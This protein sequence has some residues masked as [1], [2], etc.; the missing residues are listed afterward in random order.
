MAVTQ[1]TDARSHRMPAEER[2]QEVIAA[3]I[4]EFARRG[5][6]GTTAEDIARRAGITQPYV[7][8]LFGTKK[9]LF[10]I[11]VGR[12]FDRIQGLFEAALAGLGEDADADARLQAMG[13]SYGELLADRSMLL[14]QMQAYAAGDDPEVRALVQKRFGDL[15]EWIGQVSGAQPIEVQAFFA[16]G[17]LLNVGASIGLDGLREQWAQDCLGAARKAGKVA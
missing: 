13:E 6:E 12:V 17:M 2:R 11:A 10:L 8:R 1:T 5:L 9:S 4:E 15:Y 3:A 14:M 16:R 7:F